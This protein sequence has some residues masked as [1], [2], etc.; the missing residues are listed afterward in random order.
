MQFSRSGPDGGRARVPRP[1][2]YQCATGGCYFFK[3]M[4]NDRGGVLIFPGPVTRRDLI[5]E[6][7]WGTHPYMRYASLKTVSINGFVEMT[8]WLIRC[9]PLMR[10][11]KAAVSQKSALIL[12]W[13]LCIR[14]LTSLH[15]M[16]V[17]IV[18][19]MQCR[20]SPA[21]SSFLRIDGSN[22]RKFLRR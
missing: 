6:G 12:D 19:N 2:F 13:R 7:F 20:S 16:R 17:F 22:C 3:H 21:N 5:S 9:W 4:T 18:Q 10:I 1:I 8:C 15:V 11:W 14:S